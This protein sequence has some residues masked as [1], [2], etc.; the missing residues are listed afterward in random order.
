M[1]STSYTDQISKP[2]FKTDSI[3]KANEDFFFEAFSNA[4][5]L[6]IILDQIQELTTMKDKSVSYLDKT[7]QNQPSDTSSSSEDEENTD[8]E[9]ALNVIEETFETAHHLP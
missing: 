1:P 3:P 6:K 9:A 8:T 5:F 2:F 4:H 7:C